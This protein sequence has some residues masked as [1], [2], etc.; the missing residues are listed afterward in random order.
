MKYEDVYLRDYE[1]PAQ[2]RL[3]L[4]RYFEYYNHLRRHRSLDRQMPASIY[5][6]EASVMDRKVVAT[7]TRT[8]ILETGSGRS[9]AAIGAVAPATLRL[10]NSSGNVTHADSS[11]LFNPG[12]CPTHGDKLKGISHGSNIN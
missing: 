12:I 9:V 2:A 8:D 6:L 1:T 10:R 4:G 5:G 11:T 3:G 7:P